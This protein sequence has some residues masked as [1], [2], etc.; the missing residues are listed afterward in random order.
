M[1]CN[2]Y[3]FSKFSLSEGLFLHTFTWG[4]INKEYTT[5]LGKI[6]KTKVEKG[7]IIPYKT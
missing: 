4:I 5:L 2:I 6:P 1:R 7:D 3:C